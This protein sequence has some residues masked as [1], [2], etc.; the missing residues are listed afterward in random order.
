MVILFVVVSI[1]TLITVTKMY[2]SSHILDSNELLSFASEAKSAFYQ[3]GY[4]D[5]LN[6]AILAAQSENK[7]YEIIKKIQ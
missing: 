5:W 1:T 3:A 7:H 6:S 4:V 2:S